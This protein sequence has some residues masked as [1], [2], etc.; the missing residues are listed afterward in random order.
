VHALAAT[1]AEIGGMCLALV[2]RAGRLG[3]M[4]S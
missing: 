2:D 1:S 4:R 3:I